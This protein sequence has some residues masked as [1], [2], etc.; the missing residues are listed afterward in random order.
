M[1]HWL[2]EQ[3]YN[4]FTFD[5]RGFGKSEGKPGFK[6]VVSDANAALDYVRKMPEV[7]ANKL[8]VLAQSLGGNKAIAAIGEGNK[9]GIKAMVVDSTFYGYK[10]IA[11][12]KVKG[13][14]ILVS[15]DLSAHRYI[16]RLHPIPVMFVHGTDD[17]VIPYHHSERLFAL[18]KQPKHLLTI[19]NGRHLSALAQLRYQQQILEWMQQFE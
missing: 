13:S 1:V 12:D 16:Q 9:A 19:K 4:V 10:A 7:D 14:Q 2:P 18:A 5:Y 8:V 15:D 6:E 17:L 11:K 3:G